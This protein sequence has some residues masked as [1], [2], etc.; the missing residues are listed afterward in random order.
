LFSLP[1]SS[2]VPVAPFRINDSTLEKT[3]RVTPGAETIEVGDSTQEA[4]E[5]KMD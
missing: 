2:F 5:V 1:D 3:L 4:S